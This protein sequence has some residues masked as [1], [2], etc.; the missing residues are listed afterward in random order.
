[1]K[2]KFCPE[3][4]LEL[5]TIDVGDEL[6]LPFCS[7]CKVPYFDPVKTCIIAAVINEDNQIALLKQ[8]YVSKNHVLV[9]GHISLSETLE[10]CCIREVLEESGQVVAEI[11]YINSYVYPN[12]D[13][14]MVGFK[15]M[16]NKSKFISSP[17]VDEIAWYDLDGSENYLR[18]GSIARRL[19]E[20]I[21]ERKKDEHKKNKQLWGLKF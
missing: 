1:M 11:E 13:L 16:V 2:Y 17:E 18:E 14:L 4:G 20:T 3:C 15:C 5:T 8:G 9:A 7:A 6:N 12:R 19:V 10:Q 21:I